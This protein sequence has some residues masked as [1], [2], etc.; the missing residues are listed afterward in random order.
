M[1]FQPVMEAHVR[2]EVADPGLARRP[3]LVRIEVGDGVININPPAHR[4]GVRKHIGRIAQQYLFAERSGDLVAVDRYVP[5]RQIDQRLQADA[6]TLTEQ[7][8]ELA[9]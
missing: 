6:A 1:G 7:R 3:T 8:S 4:G 2:S 5:R 9:E